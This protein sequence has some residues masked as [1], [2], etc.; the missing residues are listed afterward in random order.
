MT[1]LTTQTIP[2]RNGDDVVIAAE[3]TECPYLV[4]TQAFGSDDGKDLHLTGGLHLTHTL[5][6]AQLPTGGTRNLRGLAAA[7]KDF[8]WNFTAKTH[9]VDAGNEA[10]ATDLLSRIRDFI[11]AEGDEDQGWLQDTTLLD[12]SSPATSLLSGLLDNWQESYNSENRPQIPAQGDDSPEAK[13]MMQAWYLWVATNVS[14]YGTAYLLAVLR[15]TVPAMA[16]I[17]AKQ[18]AAAWEA[19]DS[20][21]E[22]IWQW[23]KEL[24]EG[25]PLT[26]H[27]IPSGLD[28]DAL[29]RTEQ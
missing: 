7:L 28:T 11:T 8:D 18:L 1:T 15:A 9:F 25:K 27:G 29:A 21:G 16:D 19:G 12:L 20:L 24:R 17:A 13:A 4:I 23:N 6:G 2:R 5:T 14:A 3:K 22:W 26:L 10:K